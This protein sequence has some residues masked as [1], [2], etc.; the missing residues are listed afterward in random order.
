MCFSSLFNALTT[1]QHIFM[2][3]VLTVRLYCRTIMDDNSALQ[4]GLK[5]FVL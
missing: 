3:S 1:S 2:Q 5:A 4:E